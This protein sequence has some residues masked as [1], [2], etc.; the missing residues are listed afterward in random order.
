MA[1]SCTETTEEDI[2]EEIIEQLEKGVWE[3]DEEFMDQIDDLDSL[4]SK[5]KF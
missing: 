4:V 3:N 1:S 5:I 2:F